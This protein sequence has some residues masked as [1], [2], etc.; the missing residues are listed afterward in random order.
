[1]L[2]AAMQVGCWRTVLVAHPPDRKHEIRIKEWCI[3]PDCGIK[4]EVTSQ[5]PPLKLDQV[6]DGILLFAHIAWMSDS[7]K[8]SILLVNGDGRSI[9][10]AF[11][12][13]KRRQIAFSEVEAMTSRSI[14][15][16]YGLNSSDLQRYGGSAIEWAMRDDTAHRRYLS[17]QR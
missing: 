4:A 8:M 17:N 12:T 9:Q 1:M 5:F 11:D 10:T 15:D 7:T 3:A 16:T 13:R 14:T 2:Y 6:T